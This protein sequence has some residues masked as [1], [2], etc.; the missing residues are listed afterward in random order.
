MSWCR[1]VSCVV[2][3]WCLLQPVHSLDTTLLAF[4]L[5]HFAIQGQTCLLLQVYLDFVLLLSFPSNEKK[6]FFFFFFAVSSRRSCRSSQTVQLQLLQHSWGIDFGDCDAEWF[7]LEM[8]RDHAV[9]LEAVPKYCIS[10][11]FVDYESYSLSSTGFL[12]TL[13]NIMVFWIKFVHSHPFQF[14]DS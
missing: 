10:D 7:A 11:S 4:A 2:G 3:K 8:N 13:V 1:A 6:I 5:L 12:P 14:T 9:V